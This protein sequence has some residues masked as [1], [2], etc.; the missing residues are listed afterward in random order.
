MSHLLNAARQLHVSLASFSCR[1]LAY[2]ESVPSGMCGSYV[3]VLASD[4][5]HVVG[6]LSTPL[7]WESLSR[8]LDHD[9][10]D[11]Q[12]RGIVEGA[13]ELSR[14]VGHAFREQL[15]G[16]AMVG[17]P[18]FADGLVSSGRQVEQQA[19]DVA[20]GSCSVL[21]VLFSR[22]LPRREIA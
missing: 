11:A 4:A 2:R 6:L 18:L 3:T 12:P 7:G 21:L 5:E 16:D 9:A 19:V 14:I 17:A 20:F 15:R 22:V 8:A 13:C 1:V 10:P